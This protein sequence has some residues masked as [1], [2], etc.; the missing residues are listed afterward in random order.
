MDSNYIRKNFPALN[1]NFIFMDNAGGS[2]VL[3]A[4]IDRIT[5]YFH[6][7]NVQLGATYEISA[8][9]GHELNLVHE[10]IAR[11]INASSPKE[12]IIGPSSTM[13]LRILSICISQN[14]G[15]GDEIIVTNS[16][17]EA[18]VSC[19]TDL[20]KKGIVVRIWHLDPDT[21]E[22]NT[23]QLIGLLSER[24]KLVAMVH[25]SNILGTINP[26]AEIA[27]ITHRSGALFCVDGVAFAP[28][29]QIDVQLFDVDFYVFSTYK[30][31]GPHQAIMYGKHDLLKE[32][33]GL[34]HYFIKKEEVPYKF[35]PGNFNFELTYCL[36]A[37][38]AYFE[39]IYTYHFP[40]EPDLDNFN[41]YR[42]CYNLFANHEELLAEKLLDFLN[43]NKEIRIIGKKISDKSERVSTI[44]FVHSGLKS[45]EI[46]E[47]VDKHRIGIR[48]GDFYAKKLIED[49]N[50]VKNNGVVRVSMLHYNT[51]N[52][53]DSLIHAFSQIF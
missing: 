29:R 13:L 52:E 39:H 48:Y 18:N 17:H 10:R 21:L 30:L 35:Q 20:Q 7:F 49:T 43:T 37:I 8:R 34:N 26:I 44:S 23:E 33:E 32:M 12:I 31:F 4:V 2:Q 28:H 45:N 38:P 11:F 3:G 42:R 47:K 36:S 46:V 25:T 22:F 15:P 41:K 9:A 14:W 24:T 6:K 51:L 16:D 40:G 53:V 27:Q 19:W 5:E 50:L 1:Q